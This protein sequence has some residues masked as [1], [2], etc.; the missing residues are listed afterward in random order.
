LTATLCVES[1]G[2]HRQSPRWTA[3]HPRSSPT[4]PAFLLR[5]LGARHLAFRP[6][7]PPHTQVTEQR[8]HEPAK[9]TGGWLMNHGSGEGWETS[10]ECVPTTYPPSPLQLSSAPTQTRTRGRRRGTPCRSRLSS[11]CPPTCNGLHAL[12]I[13]ASLPPPPAHVLT[14]PRT[15]QRAW[16]PP[17][18]TGWPCVGSKSVEPFPQ[19]HACIQAPPIDLVPV[20]WVGVP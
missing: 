1:A 12:C 13:N 7:E 9:V 11:A 10:S 6:S 17:L 20:L 4:T 18:P 8:V 16:S 14:S 2:E 3:L 5:D 15:W 19:W